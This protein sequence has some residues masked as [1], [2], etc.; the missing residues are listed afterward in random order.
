MNQNP[1]QVGLVW[2]HNSNTPETLD[3]ANENIHTLHKL[4]VSNSSSRKSVLHVNSSS[5]NVI[6]KHSLTLFLVFIQM[7]RVY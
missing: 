1:Q 4:N 2:P 5:S 3:P 7:H 6:N